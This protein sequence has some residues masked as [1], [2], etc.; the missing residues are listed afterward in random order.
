[1]L[2]RKVQVHRTTILSSTTKGLSNIK[3]FQLGKIVTISS[4][5]ISELV[6]KV[7]TI[8]GVHATPWAAYFEGFSRGFCL[9]ALKR[10]RDCA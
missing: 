5:E 7:T 9:R 10:V 8:G 3:A 4:Y 2:N 6:E 1:M